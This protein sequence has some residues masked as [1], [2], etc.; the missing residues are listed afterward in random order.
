MF[1]RRDKFRILIKVDDK[2]N[3]LGEIVNYCV[4][5]QL[6]HYL[7]Y[8]IEYKHIE[9]KRCVHMVRNREREGGERGGERER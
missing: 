2:T 6:V 5:V 1:Q 8:L 4:F 3:A 9:D 7:G